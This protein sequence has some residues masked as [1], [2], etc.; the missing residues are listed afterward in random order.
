MK[1]K[2]ALILSFFFFLNS[3]FIAIPMEEEW[4]LVVE[5][6][7]LK[8]YKRTKLGSKFKELKI[9]TIFNSNMKDLLHE[10]DDIDSYVHW[11]YKCSDSYTIETLS[12]TEVVT[13]NLANMPTPIWDRDIISYSKYQYDEKTKIHSYNS[14]TPENDEK[15][16]AVKDKIVRVK[17]YK[18]YWSLEEIG[19]NKIRSINIMHM[20][21]GGSIPAWL[22]NMVITKGPIQSMRALQKRLDER[23]P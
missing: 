9:V 3:S 15:Y 14:Y 4:N 10:I 1:F 8:V 16:A 5:K 13:Y 2:I 17:D 21:P 19:E 23:N 12:A 18:A 20:E 6:E 7:D 22:N 11:V